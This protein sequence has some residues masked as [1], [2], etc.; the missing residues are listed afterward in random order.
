MK[1]VNGSVD[2]IFRAVA[3]IGK[4]V[5]EM[6]LVGQV[7][8]EHWSDKLGK[9]RDEDGLAAHMVRGVKG[10]G[11]NFTSKVDQENDGSSWFPAKAEGLALRP[12][13]TSIASVTPGSKSSGTWASKAEAMKALGLVEDEWEDM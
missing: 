7:K 5:R 8:G 3:E 2:G 6:K 12:G 11:V 10:K 4:E 1:R 9:K 13:V